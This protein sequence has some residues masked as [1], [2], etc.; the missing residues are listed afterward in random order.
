MRT[1]FLYLSSESPGFGLYFS[2]SP[3]AS[4]FALQHLLPPPCFSES[5]LTSFRVQVDMVTL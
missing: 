1:K 3:V 2:T 5:A 4:H